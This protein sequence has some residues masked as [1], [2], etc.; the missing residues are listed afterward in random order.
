MC[1]LSE[2][3][4]TVLL[5][6]PPKGGPHRK[7]PRD[8]VSALALRGDSLFLGSDEGVVL[9]RLHPRR[10]R[11]VRVAP[12]LPPPRSSGPAQPDR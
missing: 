1:E 11:P 8:S 5:D 4:R 10:R 6:L 12:G 2:P 7:A 9:D 3:V